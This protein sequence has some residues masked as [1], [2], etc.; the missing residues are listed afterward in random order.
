MRRGRFEFGI[1]FETFCLKEPWM[2][3][4]ISIANHTAL[5][6]RVGLVLV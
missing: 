6:L 5:G 4:E 1:R 2:F 3:L